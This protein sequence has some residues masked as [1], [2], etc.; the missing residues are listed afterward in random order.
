MSAPPTAPMPPTTANIDTDIEL[1]R[2]YSLTGTER[3]DNAPA[4][5]AIDAEKANTPI[6]VRVRSSPRVAHATGLS[7]MA[8]RRRP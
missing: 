8:M 1:S 4:S 7:F 3:A 6:L 5:P 2:S